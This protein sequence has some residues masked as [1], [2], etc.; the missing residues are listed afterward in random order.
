MPIFDRLINWGK[1]RPDETVLPT[2]GGLSDYI[3]GK[4]N[5]LERQKAQETILKAQE[6]QA[7]RKQFTQDTALLR[8][9]LLQLAAPAEELFKRF[10]VEKLLKEARNRY[11]QDAKLAR[12]EPWFYRDIV[13]NPDPSRGLYGLPEAGNFQKWAPTMVGKDPKIYHSLV[14]KIK[15]PDQGFGFTLERSV[16]AQLLEETWDMTNPGLGGDPYGRGDLSGGIRSSYGWVATGRTIFVD[17][18]RTMAIEAVRSELPGYPYDLIYS[19]YSVYRN[20]TLEARNAIIHERHDE[21]FRNSSLY[22]QATGMVRLGKGYLT[23]PTRILVSQPPE[24]LKQVI[25][26]QIAKELGR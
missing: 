1:K 10:D 24:V 7:R 17:D 18:I 20:N 15:T 4:L 21:A 5:D 23:P 16:P 3:S 2:S 13:T 11:W 25:G 14:N 6:D 8:E 19:Y 22:A 9:Y 12:I 26:D